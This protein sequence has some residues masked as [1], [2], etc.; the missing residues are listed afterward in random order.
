MSAGIKYFEILD[1][2]YEG[3]QACYIPNDL[4]SN[5]NY[6]AVMANAGAFGVFLD[7]VSRNQKSI[8]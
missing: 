8:H 2:W 6:I 1:G 5:L 3:T 4:Q 7:E